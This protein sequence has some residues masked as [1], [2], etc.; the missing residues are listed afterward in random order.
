VPFLEKLASDTAALAYEDAYT[1]ELVNLDPQHVSFLP[2][3]ER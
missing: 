2:S 1:M 3:H